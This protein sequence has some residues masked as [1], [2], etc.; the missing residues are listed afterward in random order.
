[1]ASASGIC[2]QEWKIEDAADLANTISNEK[3]TANLRDGIPFPY[4]EKDANEFICKTLSAEENTQY[5]FS[6]TFE[7]KVIGSIGVFRRENVHRLTAEIGYYIGEPYWGK[8][9]MTDAIK[10][11][12]GYVFDNT[13]IVRI[14]AT[15]YSRNKA[16]CRTLEKAGFQLEGIMRCEAVKNG[17][18]LDSM[19][20][21]LIKPMDE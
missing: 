10:Q 2:L 12:C 13:D 19:M 14:F 3:V 15:P 18:M 9:F 5:A 1:V 21:A 16:S 7:G 6:I 4:T 11:M 20:Y 17:E 8:G